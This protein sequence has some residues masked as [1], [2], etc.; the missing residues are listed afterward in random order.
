MTRKGRFAI[1]SLLAAGLTPLAVGGADTEANAGSGDAH[2]DEMKGIVTSID[3]SHRFTLAQHRSHISHSSHGSHQSHRSYSYQIVP[4]EGLP[5]SAVASADTRNEMS[6]PPNSVLPSSPAIAKKLKVL[7]GTSGKFKELVMRTQI[8]LLAKGY[9]AGEVNGQL[10]ARTVAALYEYQ[11]DVGQIP[12]G[13]VTS[14]VLSSLEL[15][16]SETLHGHRE[17]CGHC[18]GR[19]VRRRRIWH[20]FSRGA[21][22]A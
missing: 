19:V 14:E 9:E 13:K 6:T 18:P 3:E 15:L 5:G 17:R 1:P 21:P 7:P 10:H 20:A 16:R 8:A 2:L 22:V 4:G 12:S 11:E